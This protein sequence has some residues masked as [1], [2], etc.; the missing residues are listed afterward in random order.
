MPGSDEYHSVGM[1]ALEPQ[2]LNR[3][4][5]DY[6]L[7]VEAITAIDAPQEYRVVFRTVCTRSAGRSGR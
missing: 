4:L 7:A 1:W 3:L 6:G 2:Q 5:V